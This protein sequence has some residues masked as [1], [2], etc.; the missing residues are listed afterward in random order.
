M[1]CTFVIPILLVVNV[2]ARAIA[3]PLS[4]ESWGLIAAALIAALASLVISRL[5]FQ[6][7]L[8][9]YRSASS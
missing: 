8:A 7:A 4:G 3:M 9:K 2:P 6:A 1:L 5:V